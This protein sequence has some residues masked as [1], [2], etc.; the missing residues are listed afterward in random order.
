M[1]ASM[2]FIWR[3]VMRSSFTSSACASIGAISLAIPPV[4]NSAT[5]SGPGFT[6]ACTET[7]PNAAV[8][9]RL[10]QWSETSPEIW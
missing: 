1:N 5:T 6:S 9:S 8:R 3:E 2:F 4:P 7:A 10:S